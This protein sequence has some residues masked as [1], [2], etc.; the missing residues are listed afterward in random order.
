MSVT[1]YDLSCGDSEIAEYVYG[2]YV[3]YDDYQDL[4]SE[5]DVLQDKYDELV[6]AIG[7]LYKGV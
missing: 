1:R 2:N 4:A 3:T 7:E 5:Y 6:A